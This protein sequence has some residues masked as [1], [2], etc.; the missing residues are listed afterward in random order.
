MAERV[1]LVEV[2]GE[3][4][5]AIALE[6]VSERAQIEVGRVRVVEGLQVA[7]LP[8]A[9]QIAVQHTGPADASFK[10][11]ELER[12]EPARHAIEEKRLADGL[13][14]SREV[15]DMIVDKIGIGHAGADALRSGVERGNDF[16]FDALRPD[17]IV[18]VFAIQPK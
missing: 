7:L 10:E 3:R 4:L 1:K 18:V 13:T 5:R 16:E 6:T 15:S 14:G 12:R 2:R 11:G 17:R 8:M 9:D